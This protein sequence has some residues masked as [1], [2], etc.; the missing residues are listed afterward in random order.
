MQT[1]RSSLK[2]I[3]TRISRETT[4]HANI[5]LKHLHTAYL[6]HS[7]HPSCNCFWVF[8]L[9][10]GR[11]LIQTIIDI[12]LTH[13]LIIGFNF[14]EGFRIFFKMDTT[15]LSSKLPANL[16]LKTVTGADVRSRFAYCWI[17]TAFVISYFKAGT[18]VNICDGSALHCW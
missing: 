7:H 9:K 4:T 10:N 6:V 5:V 12:D 14:T 17:Q 11:E 16:C 2:R 1:S 13:T 15:I 8:L 3:F 18:W